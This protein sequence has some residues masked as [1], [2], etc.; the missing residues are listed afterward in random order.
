[1]AKINRRAN[2]E[3]K[4]ELEK[5]HHTFTMNEVLDVLELIA[6]KQWPDIK[7]GDDECNLWSEAKK[8]LGIQY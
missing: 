7:F 6:T 2:N 5:N 4:R 3:D 8:V 1:M